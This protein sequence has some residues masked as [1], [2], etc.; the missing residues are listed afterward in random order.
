MNPTSSELA[1]VRFLVELR[2]RGMTIVPEGDRL[3]VT[4]KSALTPELRSTLVA[5]RGEVLAALALETRILQ[6]PLDRFGR[7][8]RSLEVQVPW[9]PETLW[10][11]PGEKQAESLTKRGVSRGRIWTARE[12]RFLWSIPS[13]DK[14]MVEKLGQI[15][16][17]L[18]GEFV[19][20]EG[21]DQGNTRDA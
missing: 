16:A 20:L 19:S 17:E 2:H 13:I 5:R 14:G 6:M 10:F 12:L 21:P 8:G 4:P 1:G 15:K 7:E 18:G 9:L 11:V 3:R